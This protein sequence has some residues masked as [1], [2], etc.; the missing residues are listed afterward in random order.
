MT[1]LILASASQVR[2]TLLRNAGVDFTVQPAD[3][4]EDGY[5]DADST[6]SACETPAGYVADNTD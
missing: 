4:D 3:V 6:T 5:G 2:A 1:D